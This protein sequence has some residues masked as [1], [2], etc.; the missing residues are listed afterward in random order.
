M[1][2]D[3]R[4]TKEAG[5]AVHLTKPIGMKILLRAVQEVVSS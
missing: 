3:I 4:R 2:E 5:F 1:E